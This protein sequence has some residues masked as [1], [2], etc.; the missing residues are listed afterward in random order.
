[1]AFEE[2]GGKQM[3]ARDGYAIRLVVQDRVAWR[4]AGAVKRREPPAA[5]DDACAVVGAGGRRRHRLH[6]G[7]G[8]RIRRRTGRA[9]GGRHAVR[10]HEL[11]GNRGV[12]LAGGAQISDV[13]DERAQAGDGRAGALRQGSGEP[14]V[15]DVLMRD[16]QQLEVADVDAGVRERH[17]RAISRP[18]AA[19]CRPASMA[20]RAAGTRSPS[21]L[22]G[23]SAPQGGGCQPKARRRR[24]R[25]PSSLSTKRPFRF[26]NQST[27]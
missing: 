11:P 10:G 1:M 15:V 20:C 6:P 25:L 14:D 17:F 18:P 5:G 16:D 21:R 9:A 19:H 7:R 26:V 23:G 12:H 24:Q 4:M 3:V 2:I 22:R 8:R 27:V 13:S